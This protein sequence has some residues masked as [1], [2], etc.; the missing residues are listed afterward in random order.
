MKLQ[1]DK[2][3][4]EAIE[5]KKGQLVWLDAKHIKSLRPT[6]KL[7]DLYFG[8]FA[9][10]ERVGQG[11]YKLKLPDHEG[12]NR[13]HPV[14]NEKLLKPYKTP[15]YEEQKDTANPPGPVES[16]DGEEYEVEKILDSRKKGRGI[17]YLV[18]W[19]GYSDAENSWQPRIN[20]ENT[21]DLVKEFHNANPDKPKPA[22][23]QLRINNWGE[24]SSSFRPIT[25]FDAV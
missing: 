23:K 3:R 25:S 20:V 21:I 17:Q 12:W 14:F 2:H 8:P 24:I 19:K 7:D 10:E 13:K 11:A 1:F 15:V 16:D 22:T 4:N 6:K 5:Y 9:V 18:K